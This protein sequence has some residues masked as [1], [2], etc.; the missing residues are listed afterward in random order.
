[1]ISI[2]YLPQDTAALAAL[3][4][5]LEASSLV[6]SCQQGPG[7]GP[8][9][10]ALVLAPTLDLALALAGAPVTAKCPSLVKLLEG[11]KKSDKYGAAVTQAGKC[12]GSGS[13][14]GTG[15]G[16]GNG[17]N[18]GDKKKDKNT[19]LPMSDIHVSPY[20][21]TTTPAPLA[22]LDYASLGLMSSLRTLFTAALNHAFPQVALAPADLQAAVITRCSNPAFGDFQCNNA[23][24]LGKWFKTLGGFG[25]PVAPK[26]IAGAI[27]G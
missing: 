5:R 10:G 23:M 6:R 24:G 9:L 7:Q 20:T 19:A 22:P 11:V 4:T 2:L 15:S 13:G 18:S 21:P 3:L 8:A 16:S 26:D 17:N 27:T 14:T 1:L 25:G 12:T